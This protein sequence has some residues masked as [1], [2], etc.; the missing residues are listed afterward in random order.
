MTDE[1]FTSFFRR[2]YLR[3]VAV[4]EGILHDHQLAEDVAQA[5]ML[6]VYERYPDISDGDWL[7]IRAIAI[8]A[9]IDLKRR[10]RDQIGDIPDKE[11]PDTPIASVLVAEIVAEVTKAVAELTPMQRQAIHLALWEGLSHAQIAQVQEVS[12][13]SV[14]NRIRYAKRIYIRNCVTLG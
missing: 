3:V 11:F 12:T 14:K 5:T 1:P 10:R 4:A 6:R 2:N 7:L 8:N 9:A 13:S